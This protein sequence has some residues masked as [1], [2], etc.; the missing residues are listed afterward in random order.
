MKEIWKPIPG[1]RK[2]EVSN[3][4]EI[5][6]WNTQ[7]GGLAKEPRL[8]KKKLNK[9]VGYYNVGITYDDGTQK[10]RYLHRLI[11]Q[12]FLGDEKDRVVRHLDDNRLNNSLENLAWGTQKANMADAIINGKLPTG[13]NCSNSVLSERDIFLIGRMR[14]EG[15]THQAISRIIGV[16]RSVVTALLSGKTYRLNY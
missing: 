12:A 15:L 2:Y 7:K 5:R 10:T 1:A 9:K 6:S 3:T 8:M 14:K 11:A 4:G 16:N 13:V